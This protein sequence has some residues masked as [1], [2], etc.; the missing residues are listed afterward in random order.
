ML[1]EGREHG[2]GLNL[3]QYADR[4]SADG[5][6]A[7]LNQRGV[8]TARVLTLRPAQR[9][10]RLRVPAA[11]GALREKLS[12]LKLP[13]GLVFQACTDAPAASAASATTAPAKPATGAAPSAAPPAAASPPAASA[14]PGSS[15]SPGAS[16]ASAAR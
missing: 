3:G 16:T 6:L 8:R 5:A 9:V 10:V 12:A 2:P 7:A 11:D 15:A 13:T 14:S 4:A 1:P